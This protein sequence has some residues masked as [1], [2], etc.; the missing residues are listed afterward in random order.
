MASRGTDMAHS[1]SSSRGCGS[2]GG[3]TYQPPAP[4]P[5]H[6]PCA[7]GLTVHGRP[8]EK[9][10]GCRS[11]RGTAPVA[12]NYHKADCPTLAISC[13]TKQALRDCAKVALCDFLRCVTET[14]CPEG[15]FDLDVLR[16]NDKLGD[17]LINCV[18]QLACS[19]LHCVPEA[20][21]P[22]PCDELP[23]PI[24]CLPCDY[25]VEVSR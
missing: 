24:D 5:V 8:K 7:G 17:E 1:S 12:R 2:C 11:C 22:E 13:E 4:T 3:G 9:A 23:A 25:A 15:D 21:C 6:D 14:L 10:C 19:F 16:K 18:G 20:L